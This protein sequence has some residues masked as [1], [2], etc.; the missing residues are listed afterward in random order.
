[1]N[2]EEEKVSKREKK[3]RRRKKRERRWNRQRGEGQDD[4]KSVC[5]CFNL[6][7]LVIYSVGI[8]V[9]SKHREESAWTFGSQT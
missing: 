5:C 8:S 2:E 7:F 3:G 1:M 4:V 9:S 6:L